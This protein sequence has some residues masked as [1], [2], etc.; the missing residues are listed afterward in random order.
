MS[1]ASSSTPTSTSSSSKISST[2]SSSAAST[3]TGSW[4]RQGY[5]SSTAGTSSGL[6]FLNLNGGSPSGLWSTKFGS[7]LSYAQ[8]S[9]GGNAASSTVLADTTLLDSMEVILFT[10]KTCASDN[11]CGYYRPGTVA[12]HGFGGASK[13]FLIEFAMPLNT[14]SANMPAIWMLNALIPRTNEYG[15]CQCWGNTDGCGELDLFEVLDAGNTR[16]V[17]SLHGKQAGGDSDYFTRPTSGTM[18]AAIVMTPGQLVLK[19]L[20]SDFVFGSSLSSADLAS[21][22]GIGNTYVAGSNTSTVTLS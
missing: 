1:S 2:T 11:G 22:S 7:S 20:S 15:T 9:G 4:A 6:T 12:Y 17:A 16:M 21:L 14:S 19:V 3:A 18:K 10:D 8:S 5:Y 13:I